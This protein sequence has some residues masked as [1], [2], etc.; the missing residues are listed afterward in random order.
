MSGRILTVFF[1]SLICCLALHAQEGVRYKVVVNASNPVQTISKEK[2]SQIFLKKITNWDDG[3][4]IF[5]VDMLE[6]SKVRLN[7]SSTIH[8]RPISKIKAYW[9]KQIFTEKSVPPPQMM[10]EEDILTFV[11]SDPGAI[12]YVSGSTRVQGHAVKVVIVQ[13]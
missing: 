6:E 7:F 12:G 10:D 1:V 3:E 9:K 5:P 8:E 11:A 13:N 4:K 2:L